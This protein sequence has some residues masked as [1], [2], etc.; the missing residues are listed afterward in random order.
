MTFLGGRATLWG[1]ILGAGILETGQQYLAYELGG[2]Q[3][4]L[5]A[6]ALIFLLIMLFLPRGILPTL[7]ER[8][9]RRRRKV[10]SAD[11]QPSPSPQMEAA[12]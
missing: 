2:S 10:A 9:R 5:I 4:Y 6:Y 3:F 11:P 12:A 8:L 1:P 7:T